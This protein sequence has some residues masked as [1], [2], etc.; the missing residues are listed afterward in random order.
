[1]QVRMANAVFGCIKAFKIS[2]HKKQ[3]LF[4]DLFR[5]PKIFQIS[6]FFPDILIKLLFPIS[7]NKIFTKKIKYRNC[8][9]LLYRGAYF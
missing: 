4:E 8:M 6:N 2:L 1:M 7:S 9:Y 3:Y 5:I